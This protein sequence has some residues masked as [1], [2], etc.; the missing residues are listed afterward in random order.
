MAKPDVEMT[1]E[2][3]NN[4]ILLNLLAE[5]KFLSKQTIFKAKNIWMETCLMN[6]EDG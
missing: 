5:S 3:Q 2:N 4:V 6:Q 1:T